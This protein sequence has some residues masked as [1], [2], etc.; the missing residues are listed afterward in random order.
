MVIL[1]HKT[2][3]KVALH[4]YAILSPLIAGT[5]Q[6]S[7]NKAFFI[8]ASSRTY[9]YIDG[10]DTTYS[11]YTLE[12]WYRDYQ[13][14]GFDGLFPKQRSDANHHR[15]IDDDIASQIIYLKKEYPR[16]PAT[17][18][19]Q[20]LLDNGTIRE[21]DLSLSTINRFIHQHFFSK[22]NTKN[23]DMR[24][25]ERSHINEV[26]NGD[27]SVGP[28]IK[29]N[30]K[31]FRT[32][33]IALVDD[34]S[35]MVTGVD[36]FLND[37]FVN[38]MGVIK[39]AVSRYGK[40]KL[41]N[42]DNGANYRSTQ[43]SLISARLGSTVNYCAPYTPTSKAKIE[44]WFRTMKDQWMSQLH[45]DDFKSLEELRVSL[46]AYV[47]HYNQ[48]IHS[49]LNGLTPQDRFFQES[50]LII[51]VDEAKIDKIFLLEI[52]RKVSADNVIRIENQD[53]E[54]NYRYAGQK[55]LIRYSPDLSRVFV[56]DRDTDELSE[57]HLLDKQA[58]AT[59]KRQKVRLTKGE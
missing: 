17:L 59:I 48:T 21:E 28:Y 31:K 54:V 33:I 7:S 23:K 35:R 51:R 16:L 29:L 15:K 11:W 13:K 57:L 24:R 22:E 45:M 1:D 50:S 37:N 41:F 40:P 32:Y 34:A 27:S 9:E 43:M 56:V 5:Y 47:Q 10:K 38:L 52:E 49:S 25:Y 46:T 19:R 4:R 36:I 3:E 42:F 39:S 26:W 44:R 20:K 12:R 30:G 14:D 6:G 58:N 2:R 55:L 8:E 18:I 53:F